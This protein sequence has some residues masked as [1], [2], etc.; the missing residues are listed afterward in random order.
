MIQT[1][2]FRLEDYQY[3]YPEQACGSFEDTRNGIICTN[4]SLDLECYINYLQ[5]LESRK[6][7]WRNNGYL[8][9]GMMPVVMAPS[10]MQRRLSELICAKLNELGVKYYTMPPVALLYDICRISEQDIWMF[11][12]D[13][14]KVINKENVRAVDFLREVFLK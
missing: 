10:F 14:A 6:D 3:N 12:S 9:L 4:P 8:H 7:F 5:L 2:N 13:A 11:R 1:Y